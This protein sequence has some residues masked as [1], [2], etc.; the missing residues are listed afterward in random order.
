MYKVHIEEIRNLENDAHR[1]K[2]KQ[3]GQVARMGGERQVKICSEWTPREH[4]RRRTQREG[5][6][7]HQQEIEKFGQKF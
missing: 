5:A 2:W 7:V 6:G 4:K 1:L 3:A